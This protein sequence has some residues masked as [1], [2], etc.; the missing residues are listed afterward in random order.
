LQAFKELS[1]KRADL[2]GILYPVPEYIADEISTA[3]FLRTTE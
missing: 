3:G 2:S 1:I